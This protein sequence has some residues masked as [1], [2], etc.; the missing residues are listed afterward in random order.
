MEKYLCEGCNNMIFTHVK[1]KHELYCLNSIKNEE[2]NGLI[3]CE[4]CNE[5]IDFDD[6]NEHIQICRPEP[7]YNNII[8]TI[9]SF[10]SFPPLNNQLGQDN[11]L[12]HTDQLDHV[13]QIN[14]ND[15]NL[16]N[17]P[18][19]NI[20]SINEILNN[21]LLN[22][23]NNLL[24][25]NNINDYESMTRLG[26]Q[27]GTVKIGLD[28]INKYS[29]IKTENIKCPICSLDVIL[30]RETKCNHKFCLNCIS[31]W[32]KEN[33]TCPICMKELKLIN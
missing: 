29:T 7:N 2:Y 26:E 16:L 17:I 9:N 22:L 18:V 3:P 8:N 10:I 12:D 14:Q 25:N 20:D 31:E 5:F 23:N 27:I 21:S 13:E 32:T 30:V 19:I 33:K 1:D 15:Q 4:I 28:D 24:N 11:Q 6:F